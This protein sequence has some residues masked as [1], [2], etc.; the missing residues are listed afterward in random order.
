M[1]KSFQKS[2]IAASVG[3][4]MFAAAGTASANSLLFPFFT[5]ASGAQSVLSLSNTGTGAANQVIHYVYNY[6]LL[7]S[8]STQTVA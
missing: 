6:G 2:L 8:T 7:A 5:T 3:A 4:V 1:K